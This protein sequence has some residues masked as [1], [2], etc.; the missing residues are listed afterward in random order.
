MLNEIVTRAKHIVVSV[1]R[2]CALSY[3]GCAEN[4]MLAD[5]NVCAFCLTSQRGRPRGHLLSDPRHKVL[6]TV[7][8][9]TDYS[10][11]ASTSD[12]SRTSSDNTHKYAT[13]PRQGTAKLSADFDIVSH[14]AELLERDDHLAM[15]VAAI[16]C[17]SQLISRSDGPYKP[18]QHQVTE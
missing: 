9:M 16:E 12:L 3:S 10:P 7:L 1:L 18:T 5:G 8:N 14:Y 11:V 17:L 13:S 6:T 15:P 2:I 4:I